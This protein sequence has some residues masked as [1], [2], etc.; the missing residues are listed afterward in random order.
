MPRRRHA[1]A[2]RRVTLSVPQLL[3]EAAAARPR[4]VAA[5][6]AAG[7][8][9]TYQAWEERSDEQ[10]QGLRAAG[11]A[12]G[13]RLALLFDTE[14]W[15]DYA[16]AYVAALK[17]GAVPVPLSAGLSALEIARALR[18]AEAAAVVVPHGTAPAELPVRRIDAA[19]LEG[20]APRLGPC[21]P[22]VAEDLDLEITVRSRPLAA[23]VLRSR[24]T[25]A[26]LSGATRALDAAGVG[27]AVLHWW[28]VGAVAGQD[29]LCAA[30]LPGGPRSVVLPAFDPDEFWP[31]LH[32]FGVTACSLHPAAAE[33]LLVDAPSRS[34]VAGLRGLILAAGRVSPA[35]RERVAELLAGVRLFVGEPQDTTAPVLTSLGAPRDDLRPA[36]VSAAVKAAWHRML[37]NAAA[38]EDESFFEA[39][40]DGVRATRLLRLVED[41]LGVRVRLDDFLEHPTVAGLTRLATEAM[42]TQAP[43][44]QTAAMHPNGAA[45]SADVAPAAFSQEGMVWHECF[46]PG[47]QNL[48]GLARR[49][50]GPLDV[51][52]LGRALDEI[53]RRHEPLR[54]T[55]TAADGRLV[56]IVHPATELGL[57]CSD[58]SSLSP[59][60]RAAEVE[61]RVAAAGAVPFDLVDGPLFEVGL[62]RLADDDHALVIRTHHS[63]FDDWSV[64]VFRRQLSA[65]YDAYVSGGGPEPSVSSLTFAMFAREQRRALA[66]Q[67]GADELSYWEDELRDAPLATQ[68][69]VQDP[70]S[71]QGAAQAAGGPISITFPDG[72]TGAL[73]ALARDEHATVFTVLLAAF[74]AV[75]SGRTGQQD[76]LL[77][78]VVANR[79]RT[80]LERLIGCFTKKVPL[81]LDMR[82]DPDFV[83]MVALTRRSLLGVLQHQDLPFE[84]V[85]QEILGPRAQVH[86]L[87]PTNVVMVQGVTPRQP[88]VIP[89]LETAGLETSS[90]ATR[91]HFMS[92]PTARPARPPWGSGIYLGTFVIVSVSDSEDEISCIARGAFEGAAV[93]VLLDDYAEVVARAVATP[94]RRLSELAGPPA[95]ATN[96]NE[97]VDL[98]G[99][100]VDLGRVAGALSRSP[101][102]RR[103]GV[104][105]DTDRDGTPR[106][107]AE[108]V[109]NGATPSVDSLRTFL[110]STMPG[111]AWPASV[112]TAADESLS[113]RIGNTV[114]PRSR[115]ASR[116]LSSTSDATLLGAL[117]AEV[118]GIERCRPDDNYWQDFSFLE[119][120]AVARDAGVRIPT[121]LVTRNRTLETLA[122]ALAAA[123]AVASVTPTFR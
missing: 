85:Q 30:L 119:A 76:L 31:A 69:A 89:D 115:D 96:L 4:D 59:E 2:L 37:R 121:A 38:G 63:V 116:L 35:L 111:Y 80:E 93:R 50:R 103:A 66:G 26:A 58:I 113:D 123:R 72:V 52:A 90:R 10:A 70:G 112:T 5:Q 11:I 12:A 92:A 83:Q 44:R 108:I 82:G 102:V 114:T 6:V 61:R 78:T 109:P 8:Q 46:A 45:S 68:L 67:A 32:R 20:H 77:S 23:P 27:G 60:A 14:R 99:F 28:P 84:A 42:E 22:A 13:H 49:F 97:S 106:L 71:P 16:V 105:V 104:R 24:S 29:A 73:R 117:W 122:T 56:Q 101:E 118:L 15:T 39:G 95:A 55:F 53:V 110:W 41:A 3:A 21:P 7:P 54:S 48:P 40:G 94:S 88:L 98:D 74:G 120:L 87:V 33:A 64:G 91:D 43:A 65:L 75:V 1:V 17:S 86:G 36:D 81:R 18:A 57:T 9:L 25:D 100:R 19:S 107:T 47:C 79:N 62:L 34:S 51:C